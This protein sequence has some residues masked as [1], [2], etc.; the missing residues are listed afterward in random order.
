MKNIPFLGLCLITIIITSGV[1]DAVMG[2]TSARSATSVKLKPDI[3]VS[4]IQFTPLGVTSE[5]HNI[6]IAA[7]I[8][9]TVRGT[10][11]GP[12]K[13]RIN[14][15]YPGVY[16]YNSTLFGPDDPLG[17]GNYLSSGGVQNLINDPSRMSLPIVTL[18]F[19]HTVPNGETYRYTVMA[20]YLNQVA[21]ADEHNNGLS[22]EYFTG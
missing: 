18:Y 11:T 16:Y 6:R 19:D 15:D 3:V 8:T 5:G 22:A 14:W 7:T 21:E 10:S 2:P 17:Y 9:N 4:D 13:V 1:T 20:D 12:F